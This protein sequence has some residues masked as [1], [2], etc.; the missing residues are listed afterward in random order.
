MPPLA[1]AYEDAKSIQQ[2]FETGV[3]TLQGEMDERRI[4]ERTS[5]KRKRLKRFA[6]EMVRQSRTGDVVGYTIIIDAGSAMIVGK[7]IPCS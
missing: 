6:S 7:F 5:L 4:R 1:K 3:S 2:L